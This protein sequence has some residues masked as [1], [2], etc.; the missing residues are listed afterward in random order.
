MFE[1]YRIFEGVIIE[2]WLILGIF[3]D[4]FSTAWGISVVWLGW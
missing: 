1:P 3:N 2:N 4:A